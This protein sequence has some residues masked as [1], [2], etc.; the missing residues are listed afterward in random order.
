MSTDLFEL[1]KNT[2]L[3]IVDYFSRWIEVTKL[4]KLTSEEVIN[5]IRFI[6]AR[7][8]IPE[9]MVSDNGPQYSAE[10]YAKFARHYG[11]QHV[12]SSP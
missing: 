3:L 2:Y 9:I 8:G 1:N 4:N 6:F 7:H 12:K 10:L 11:F 5:C